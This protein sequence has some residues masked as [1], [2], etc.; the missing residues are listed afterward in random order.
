VCKCIAERT[1]QKGRGKQRACILSVTQGDDNKNIS[2]GPFSWLQLFRRVND[3][4]LGVCKAKTNHDFISLTTSNH[5]LIKRNLFLIKQVKFCWFNA[6]LIA[7]QI[8]TS[9]QLAKSRS[10]VLG[11]EETIAG[12]D[13]HALIYYVRQSLTGIR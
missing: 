8:G 6:H 1:W 13:I 3:G 11:E 12:T 4:A 2:K 9:C 5:Y 10:W 7:L